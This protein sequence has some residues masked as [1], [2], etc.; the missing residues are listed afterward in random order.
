M[1]IT[2]A[3]YPVKAGEKMGFSYGNKYWQ[4]CHSYPELFHEDGTV[5][6][7]SQYKHT[8]VYLSFPDPTKKYAELP[9]EDTTKTF[10]QDVER[11]TPIS[12]VISET[13]V[14]P[15][16]V[17]DLRDK[18]IQANAVD[19]QRFG[20]LEAPVFALA[21]KTKLAETGFSDVSVKTYYQ[22]PT[23]TNLP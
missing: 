4:T 21:L 14:I 15:L 11:S 2:L 17:Y 6:D 12:A 13:E 3:H 23:V 20:Q 18:L 7:H 10:I 19:S 22:N 16:S 5:L 8:K 9:M 1:S